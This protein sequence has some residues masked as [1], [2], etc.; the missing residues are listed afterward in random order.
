VLYQNVLAID[1]STSESNFSKAYEYDGILETKGAS[2]AIFKDSLGINNWFQFHFGDSGSSGVLFENSVFWDIGQGSQTQSSGVIYNNLTFGK[3]KDSLSSSYVVSGNGNNNVAVNNSIFYDLASSGGNKTIISGA[4][5]SDG[6]LFW[7]INAY[8]QNGT[9]TNPIT[10]IDPSD[11][12][13]GNNVPGIIYP[14]RIESNSDADNNG[15]GATVVYR[16]GRSGTLWGEDGYDE[17][18][19][20]P[21][22][23]WPNEKDIKSKMGSYSYSENSISVNGAR[24]F[25]ANND[26]SMTNYIWGYNGGVLPP[27][28]VVAIPGN[29]SIRLV[30]EKQSVSILSDMQNYFIYNSPDNSLMATVPADKNTVTLSNLI[31]GNEYELY[32]TSG[33]ASG[34]GSFSYKVTATPSISAGIQPNPPVLNTQVL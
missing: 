13:P 4:P 3:G 21:L 20:K 25:A 14:V 7:P 8:F 15:V 27:F 33:S 11:G 19:N 5:N 26:V 22:W 28:N 12:N 16:R 1:Q 9:T 18:S 32:I 31:N 24:G 29:Q 34:E 10:N 6:N 17:L 2:T 30:W 23:P